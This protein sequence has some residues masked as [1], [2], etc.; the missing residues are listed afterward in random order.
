[1]IIMDHDGLH[2]N[3][4]TILNV[5]MILSHNLKL[6]DLWFPLSPAVSHNAVVSFYI[7]SHNYVA[8]DDFV[9]A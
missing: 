6:V 5:G 9:L 2:W 1:M 4:K 8:Y 3:Y 7:F